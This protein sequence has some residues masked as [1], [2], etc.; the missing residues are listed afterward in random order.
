[1]YKRQTDGCIHAPVYAY[2]WDALPSFFNYSIINSCSGEQGAFYDESDPIA[3]VTTSVGIID[4]QIWQNK[5][6]STRLGFIPTESLTHDHE[7]SPAN[8]YPTGF[9]DTTGNVTYAASE[10]TSG[11][12]ITNELFAV[13]PWNSTSF[14]QGAASTSANPAVWE[15]IPMESADLELYYESSQSYPAKL[16]SRVGSN[17]LFIPIG[18]IVT[19]LLGTG[20]FAA[21]TKTLGFQTN[22]PTTVLLSADPTT[23]P[24]S[25][26]VVKFTRP[27]GSYTTAEVSTTYTSSSLVL[28]LIDDVFNNNIGLSYYNC[29][30]FGNGVESNRI[31]DTFNSGVIDK[32][33]KVSTVIDTQYE[34]EH[35]KYGLIYSGIYNST[36]G[37]NNLNQFIAAEK[38][39]KDINPCLLYTSPSPR[40]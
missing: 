4:S 7:I 33:V 8:L 30:S 28:D 13:T 10:N 15:T 23:S 21:N 37:V 17:N 18:S 9:S 34:I 39:T 6:G 11:E 5:D 24:V 14:G 38:I 32:G 36:S 31:S 19:T 16:S 2:N 20:V 12:P 26:D 29:F 40:D 1:M 25:G 35:R 3:G 22:I 27:D